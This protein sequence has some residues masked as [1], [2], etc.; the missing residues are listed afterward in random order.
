MSDQL[1]D[2]LADAKSG[3][4]EQAGTRNVFE[5]V[6]DQRDQIRTALPAHLSADRF[7]RTALTTLRTTPRLAECDQRSVL[8]GLMEAAQLGLEI[9]GVRGQAYLVPRRVKGRYVAVF[10]VGYRGLID[11]ASR[12]GITVEAHDVRE[13]DEFSYRLGLDPALDHVP[14]LGERGE[15][16]AYYAVARFADARTPQFSVMTRS[17]AETHRDRFAGTLKDGSPWRDHFDAM[18]RKSVILRLV[19]YLPMQVELAEAM[20]HDE[21]ITVDVGPVVVADEPDEIVEAE[22]TPVEGT[23]AEAPDA[24]VAEVAEGGEA[25]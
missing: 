20:A 12:N 13:G 1:K 7:V 3:A 4:V 22:A 19:R 15:A 2:R 17:E 9:S 23:E 25:A 16:F 11:L 5:A 21:Q 18:A 8:A 10:Q 6:R 24:E 14:S